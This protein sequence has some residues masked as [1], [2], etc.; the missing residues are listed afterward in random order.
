MI[1]RITLHRFRRSC[2]AR[3][4]GWQRRRAPGLEGGVAVDLD[5]HSHARGGAEEPPL[6]LFAEPFDAVGLEIRVQLVEDVVRRVLLDRHRAVLAARDVA[7]V[8]HVC[9][10]G[11]HLLGPPFDLV[12]QPIRQRRGLRGGCGRL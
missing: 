7:R 6:L 5:G 12:L 8:L 3:N 10:L 1:W 9:G 11:N 2:I 4:P